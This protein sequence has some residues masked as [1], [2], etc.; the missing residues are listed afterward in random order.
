[1]HRT[2]DGFIPRE[3]AHHAAAAYT[4]RSTPPPAAHHVPPLP[5]K[6]AAVATPMALRAATAHPANK[7]QPS[8][9]TPQPKRHS[10]AAP[11]PPK[12]RRSFPDR[13]QLPVIIVGAMLAGIFAQSA[14]FG[15]VLV[16]LYGIA[17]F[18]WCIASRTTFT[19]ALL[20]MVATTLLLV[21]RGNIPL[22]QNF[23]T[24]TFLLLVVGVITLTRELKKEGGRIYSNRKNI[25]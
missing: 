3:T 6:A 4:K 16:V 19:L 25:S 10:Y 23:A 15:E 11:T 13:L 8:P 7:S 18:V 5:A 20:S 14:V 1:M 22:A 9:A 17:A 21:V 24:Y 2:I 12:A